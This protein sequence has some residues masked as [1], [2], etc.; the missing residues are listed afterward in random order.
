M[1]THQDAGGRAMC[2]APIVEA[3]RSGPATAQP[4]YRCRQR[5]KQ[6]QQGSMAA[7]SF[8]TSRQGIG[9]FLPKHEFQDLVVPPRG[10]GVHDWDFLAMN[11]LHTFKSWPALSACLFFFLFSFFCSH[12]APAN[13]CP[14]HPNLPLLL[15]WR[16]PSPVLPLSPWSP[17]P[18]PPPPLPLPHCSS[19]QQPMHLPTTKIPAPFDHRL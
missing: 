11:L 2:L 1:D 4:A 14:L 8:P 12:A 9:R 17:C 6:G 16:P 15:R 7:S 5:G 19:R 3:P 10:L 18:L 13:L